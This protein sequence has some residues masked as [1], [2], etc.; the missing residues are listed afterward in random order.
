MRFLLEAD[1]LEVEKDFDSEEELDKGIKVDNQNLPQLLQIKK[2]LETNKTYDEL[3]GTERNDFIL[4]CLKRM[5]NSRILKDANL[6]IVNN[7]KESNW[8]KDFAQYLSDANNIKLNDD[9]VNLIAELI[10]TD[11]VDYNKSKNWLLNNSLYNRDVD[12]ALYTIKA[13]ALVDNDSLQ[14]RGDKNLFRQKLSVDNFKDGN[15]IF[16]SDRIR[17]ILNA[18]T[19]PDIKSN[20]KADYSKDR[21]TRS[22]IKQTLKDNK[23]KINDGD[24]DKAIDN[25]DETIKQDLIS[26]LT[27]TF[28]L[29][30]KRAKE[31]VQANYTNEKKFEELLMDLLRGLGRGA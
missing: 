1:A 7:I 20:L 5:P 9:I 21:S 24:V 16:N 23:A 28:G 8:N 15:K 19:N 3:Q 12:D 27:G 31:L 14:V 22:R 26:A 10:T 30:D 4:K 2:S 17:D 18:E 13:L 25:T 29:D 6:S 11:K